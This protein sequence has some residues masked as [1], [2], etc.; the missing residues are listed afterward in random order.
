MTI[1]KI[2][3][4]L[5]TENIIHLLLN[6]VITSVQSKSLNGDECYLINNFKGLHINCYEKGVY[7]NK[8]NGL[9][10]GSTEYEVDYGDGIKRKVIGNEV[11]YEFGTVTEED[12]IE[13]DISEYVSDENK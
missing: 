12:F 5:C 8:E 3:R 4:P 13:P 7:I 6:A 10:M 9:V 1:S 11:E 2:I